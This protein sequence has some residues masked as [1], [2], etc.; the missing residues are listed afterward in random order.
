M[1]QAI[2][3]DEQ[4]GRFHISCPGFGYSDLYF[5]DEK[6]FTQAAMAKLRELLG[7]PGLTAEQTEVARLEAELEQ[8]TQ[9]EVVCSRAL[10]HDSFGHA[11]YIIK[12]CNG[13]EWKSAWGTTASVAQAA[14]ARVRELRAEAASGVMLPDVDSMTPEAQLLELT[15]THGYE[16]H[17]GVAGK[18]MLATKP[19]AQ[20]QSFGAGG[21]T[22]ADVLRR[23]RELDAQK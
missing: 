14:A 9:Q 11:Q 22:L 4:A 17:P 20:M 1:R 3:Y 7:I 5:V 10:H 6:T 2:G 13:T 19:D 21:R 12:F 15:A 16:V 18:E 8:A 23:A